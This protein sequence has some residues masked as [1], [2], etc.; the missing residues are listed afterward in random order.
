MAHALV[1]CRVRT[2]VNAKPE[3]TSAQLGP[4]SRGERHLWTLASLYLA[5]QLGFD[6]HHHVEPAADLFF[7]ASKSDSLLHLHQLLTP[8]VHDLRGN[9]IG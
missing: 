7:V 3:F 2:H 1:R 8:L 4:S 5:G 6:L 9:V